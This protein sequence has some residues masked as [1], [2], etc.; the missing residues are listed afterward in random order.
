M[1][2]GLDG[3]FG[4]GISLLA[5]LD[6]VEFFGTLK[7]EVLL[8]FVMSLVFLLGLDSIQRPIFL[9]YLVARHQ[10]LL[11]VVDANFFLAI[12]AGC[13]ISEYCLR[14]CTTSGESIMGTASD[15]V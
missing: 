11:L 7:R 4:A 13:S 15:W 5:C 6:I 12:Y 1:R 9:S 8:L 14:F 10:G 3:T 2:I